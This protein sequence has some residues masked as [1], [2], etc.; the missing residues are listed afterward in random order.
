MNAVWLYLEA[1][2]SCNEGAGRRHVLYIFFA[3]VVAGLG[4]AAISTMDSRMINALFSTFAVFG[5]LFFALPTLV[6]G[7]LAE[8]LRERNVVDDDRFNSRLNLLDLINGAARLAL[9]FGVAFAVML[10]L[11]ASTCHVCWDV[12]S[13]DIHD[14]VTNLVQFVVLLLSTLFL[15]LLV[16]AASAMASLMTGLVDVARRKP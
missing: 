15:G 6:L 12:L 8:V 7:M 11:A 2:E 3:L 4:A 14:W 10:I 16:R 9:G 5:A 13:T 1:A